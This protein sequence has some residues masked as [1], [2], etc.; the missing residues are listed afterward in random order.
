[1]DAKEHEFFNLLNDMMLLTFTSLNSWEKTFIS[2]MHHRAMTRQLIS[3]KQKMSI[4]SISEKAS[5]RRKPS[6]RKTNKQ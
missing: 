4:L 5:K 1:M 2:D 6:S 3:P